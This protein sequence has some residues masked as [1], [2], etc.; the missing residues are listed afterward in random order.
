[1]YSSIEL[2]LSSED[3]FDRTNCS[4]FPYFAKLSRKQT[5][6]L[7]QYMNID[8]LSI[9][10]F[11]CI[12]QVSSSSSI[13]QRVMKL[14][15]YRG[16]DGEIDRCHSCDCRCQRQSHQESC[17]LWVQTSHPTHY[18][19]Q[20]QE[21]WRVCFLWLSC[22]S[23]RSA[24]QGTGGLHPVNVNIWRFCS[25]H[26]H[27]NTLDC[28]HLRIDT[29]D[30]WNR[31]FHHLIY[32]DNVGNNIIFNT[33][34]DEIA[35]NAVVAYEWTD[36]LNIYVFEDTNRPV[37]EWL[38]H[39]MDE[40][41]FYKLCYSSTTRRISTCHRSLPWHDY[42]LCTCWRGILTLH[43]KLLLPFSM[44]TW[45]LPFVSIIEKRY[46]KSTRGITIL[47]DWLE[48]LAV[49]AIPG[50]LIHGREEGLT[51]FKFICLIF[52]IYCHDTWILNVI[53]TKLNLEIELMSAHHDIEVGQIMLLFAKKYLT[54]G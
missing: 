42:L 20:C 7:P 13:V 25:S 48:W 47:V 22:P 12:D 21:N 41:P 29:V 49:F 31:W 30:H 9:I 33:D 44:S 26:Q 51:T 17:F 15:I 1:M 34:I 14:Y 8:L 32:L 3:C 37:N 46:P 39:R 28:R 19:W 18:G 35:E 50:M 5:I 53:T 27:S 2:A 6:V 10:E 38:V 52:W 45:R 36:H 54:L 40:A 23:F 24:F 16:I 11:T 4:M 43:Q